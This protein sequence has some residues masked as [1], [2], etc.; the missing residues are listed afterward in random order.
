M[1]LSQPFSCTSLEK[2]A[3][4]TKMGQG[5]K[6]HVSLYKKK[7]REVRSLHSFYKVLSPIELAQQTLQEPLVDHLLSRSW[8]RMH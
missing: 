3:L 6:S 7:E 4:G 1:A 8:W 2:V 5:Q